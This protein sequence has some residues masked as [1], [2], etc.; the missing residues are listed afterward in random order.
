MHLVC[1]QFLFGS[2]LVYFEGMLPNQMMHQNRGFPNNVAVAAANMRRLNQQHM[3]PNA[4]KFNRVIA[5]RL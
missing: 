1:T 3:P 4:G 5:L 2:Y